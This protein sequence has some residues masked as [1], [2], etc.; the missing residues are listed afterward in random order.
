MKESQRMVQTWAI[1]AGMGT[2]GESGGLW[3][4]HHKDPRNCHIYI[5]Q[6]LSIPQQSQAYL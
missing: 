4:Q 1:T 2:W 5:H 6:N 3:E